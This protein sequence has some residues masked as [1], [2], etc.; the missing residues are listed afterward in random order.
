MHEAVRQGSGRARATVSLRRRRSPDRR[1]VVGR[2]D[3][4]QSLA[5]GVVVETR[6]VA[7]LL[8][9][10]L[11]RVDGVIVLSPSQ[12]EPEAL[13]PVVVPLPDPEP[14]PEP[15]PVAGRPSDAGRVGA[16]LGEV[17]RTLAR[18]RNAHPLS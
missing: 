10:P 15:L 16:D 3:S 13:R 2:V 9:M 7:R 18:L 1:P 5:H 8:R 4:E 14:H 11:L 12:P 17:A 6:I